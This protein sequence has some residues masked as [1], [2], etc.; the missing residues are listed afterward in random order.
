MCDTIYSGEKWIQGVVA[1]GPD[2]SI[3]FINDYVYEFNPS[4]S[5]DSIILENPGT[6]VE[7]Y[8]E[9]VYL[10]GARIYNVYALFMKQSPMIFFMLT[11]DDPHLL[12]EA[13][14]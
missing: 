7:R 5:G 3:I 14:P 8:F 9:G 13:S 2:K 6:H 12:N 1:I 10:K 11:A 4:A